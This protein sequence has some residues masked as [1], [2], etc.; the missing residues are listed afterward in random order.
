MALQLMGQKMRSICALTHKLGD[1]SAISSFFM[2]RVVLV[3]R[4]DPLAIFQMSKFLRPDG[5]ILSLQGHALPTLAFYQPC[6]TQGSLFFC[7]SARRAS[8]RFP[9]LRAASEQ[10]LM[11]AQD[12]ENALVRPVQFGLDE[13][14]LV[15]ICDSRGP[16]IQNLV[17]FPPCVSD[18]FRDFR[19]FF[20]SHNNLST[21]ALKSHTRQ[22]KADFFA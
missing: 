21:V 9:R 16:P 1:K 6:Y 2:G 19:C 8:L 7:S 13:L 10:V 3:F 18:L 11:F 5:H 4:R 17:I 20:R 12:R 15:P 14:Q 22:G